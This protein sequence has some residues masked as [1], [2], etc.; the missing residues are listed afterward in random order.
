[1]LICPQ[2]NYEN[3]KH[4]KFCERCGT[5]LTQKACPECGT[6]VPYLA[7]NCENCGTFT[8][9]QWWSVIIKETSSL[10]EIEVEA[11]TTP[12]DLTK[13]A[14]EQ[15]RESQDDTE[16]VITE[17]QLNTE[18]I[19][20]EIPSEIVSQEL[21]LING[22]YLDPDE[23]YRV[24]D[25]EK[26]AF[27]EN[28][29][30]L[31]PEN[32]LQIKLI[33]DRPL[34]TSRLENI[35]KEQ[36]EQIL[37]R[38]EQKNDTVSIFNSS[39]W[40]EIGISSLALP[41]ILLQ[42]E[43]DPTIPKIHDTWSNCYYTA[44][45]LE[46]RSNFKLLSE[47][48]GDEAI[49]IAQI[50]YWLDEIAAIWQELA[51]LNYSQSLLMVDNL[52]LDE[53]QSLCLQQLYPNTSDFEPKLTD[54]VQSWQLLFHQ[55]G[56]T[57][58][59]ELLGIFQEVI[60]ETLTDI[61]ELKEKIQAIAREYSRQEA[62][63][64]Q[65]E[66]K[67]GSNSEQV[68][69][70]QMFY[71]SPGDDQPTVVLPMQL[72]SLMD[73]GYTDIGRQRDHNEDYYGIQTRISTQ[74]NVLGKT[75]EARGIYI[76]CDGMGGHAAGEV[77]SAMATETLQSYFQEYWQ[78]ELPEY[79]TIAEGILLAN[80]TLYEVNLKNSRTGSG[81]MGT[82]LV[83][84]LVQD[85]KVAIAHVGDS[86]IY[87]I[88]R[89]W[90]L[91]QLTIDHEVGQ[92]EIQRGVEPEI[93]YSRQD[94]YQLTQALGPRDNNFIK[95]DIDFFEV[96]EDTILLLCSDGLSDNNLIESHWETYLAPLLSSQANLDQGLLKLIDFANEYNGHD[97]ITGVIVRL[98]VRPILEQH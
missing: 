61:E 58:Q 81:R 15:A 43:W 64:A 92:R 42:D 72:L 52:R 24:L 19:A 62:Q 70:E 37:S 27:L 60:D 46:D 4:N 14:I 40:Q 84:A 98:K 29:A 95:P 30:S 90:G 47:A 36:G 97:N 75:I 69:T 82:T 39:L 45:L 88:T 38:I 83:M 5:S 34:A 67:S 20:A 18:K 66:E 56:R 59:G 9:K 33:D 89:K 63:A 8:A 94:A 17:I 71:N 57:Y 11:I 91:E 22:K 25:S 54:L 7:D 74:E 51:K 16:E 12:F 49:S 13:E 65:Q 3:P 21:L 1:M 73:V 79:E 93:A 32:L 80:H 78:D 10:P 96:N 55:S 31:T 76:V 28:L 23:R 87:R 41:Y 85:N 86:R 68:L 77:A 6:S 53:D 44:I 50:L 26:E 2:C 35:I 48:W